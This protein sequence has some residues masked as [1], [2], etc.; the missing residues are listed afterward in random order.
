VQGH[1]TDTVEFVGRLVSYDQDSVVHGWVRSSRVKKWVKMDWTIPSG[2]E[3][4]TCNVSGPDEYGCEAG[5][6]RTP[7]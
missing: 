5:G 7:R 6:W 4:F 1:G 3:R 2:K